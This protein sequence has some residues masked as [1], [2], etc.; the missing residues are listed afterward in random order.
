MAHTA[1]LYQRNGTFYFRLR[2]PIDLKCYFQRDE[3]K[4]SLTTAR[5]M[6]KLWNGKTEEFFIMVRSGMSNTQIKQLVE[7]YI[8]FTLQ[9]H[10]EERLENGVGTSVTETDDGFL[11]LSTVLE[12]CPKVQ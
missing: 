6:V 7:D 3:L 12:Y 9:Q 8:A 4:R 2:I 11:P 10:D 5:R 1:H